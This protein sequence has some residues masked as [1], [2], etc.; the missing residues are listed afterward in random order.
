MSQLSNKKV[1]VSNLIK[2]QNFYSDIMGFKVLFYDPIKN[3]AMLE[4]KAL[5]TIL[6]VEDPALDVTDWLT[7]SYDEPQPGKKVYF[8]GDDRLFEYKARLIENTQI[9]VDWIEKEWGDI[10]LEVTD[11][12]GYIL[13]FWGAKNLTFEEIISYYESAPV[14]LKEALKGLKDHDLDLTRAQGKWSIRQ[15]VLHLVDSDATSLAMTK[16]A[17]AEPGREFN[18]NSYNPD[19][20]AEGLDYSNRSIEIEVELFTA[21]RKHIVGL[22]QHLPNALERYVQIS[23]GPIV[24]IK[25]RIRPLMSHA[26]GHIEQINET[27]K[28]HRK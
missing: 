27:R 23:D 3:I 15:I 5:Q 14:R 10:I 26:L 16:F 1:V 2:S 17:L 9:E 21:I 8:K 20:W 12:D 11:P 18:S 7:S 19:V 25:D 6:L 13:S 24:T 28:I 4:Y 22:L